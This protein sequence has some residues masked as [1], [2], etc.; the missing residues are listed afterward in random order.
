MRSTVNSDNPICFKF[1]NIVDKVI[2]ISKCQKKILSYVCVIHDYVTITL[3]N[4][5]HVRESVICGHVSVLC[6]HVV[7]VRC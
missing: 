2:C 7:P 6:A 5:S 4:V 3:P 1:D